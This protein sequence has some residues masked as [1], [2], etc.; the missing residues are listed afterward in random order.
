LL[1]LLAICALLTTRA[2]ASADD[3]ATVSVGDNADAACTPMQPD[4]AASLVAATE[5]MLPF[6]RFAAC[7]SN[8]DVPLP[9]TP[10]TAADATAA[11]NKGDDRR[12]H[13][14]DLRALVADALAH[15]LATVDVD[16]GAN[17]NDDGDDDAATTAGLQDEA[18]NSD[19][20]VGRDW[21]FAHLMRHHGGAAATTLAREFVDDC[22]DDALAAAAP[23]VAASDDNTPLIHNSV[24]SLVADLT[25]FVNAL[26]VV[27]RFRERKTRSMSAA[28]VEAVKVVV[29]G[30]GPVGLYG[31]SCF[32]FISMCACARVRVFLRAPFRCTFVFSRASLS[33][34]CFFRFSH[35]TNK[36]KCVTTFLQ[37]PCMR[38]RAARPSAWCSNVT[39]S[40]LTFRDYY[41]FLTIMI[42]RFDN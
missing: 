39:L 25:T 15:S 20:G 35:V 28:K 23:A 10:Y 31:T 9:A 16:A 14:T 36:K 27:A 13:A 11:A 22:I 8:E 3:D 37:R 5:H 21:V 19:G 18:L 2:H 42:S 32:S 34:S 24:P 6:L 38:M 17:A 33:P 29:V 26:L 12:A 41:H 1:L 7:L 30:A 4:D 40:N